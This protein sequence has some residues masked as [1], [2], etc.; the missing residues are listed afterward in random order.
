M[1]TASWKQPLQLF[2]I[3]L[4]IVVAS[5]TLVV[6]YHEDSSNRVSFSLI[7]QHS[8]LVTQKDF[9]GKYQLVFFGF[10]SC[11]DICPTQMSKISRVMGELDLSGR[12]RRITPVMISVDPER[13]TP[14]KMASYLEYFDERFVGL[15]GSR[16][17]LKVAADAFKTVLQEAPVALTADYQLTHSSI[18]YVV[19]P[20]GR[21]V[22]YIPFEQGFR[23]MAA[24]ISAKI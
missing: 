15:T 19:D 16:S 9:A 24:R 6:L 2:F 22:D 20:Y 17:A 11:A 10:T 21:I 13:D 23:T 1:N 18:V 12:G 8:A 4:A 7:D 3:V 14:E 5:F